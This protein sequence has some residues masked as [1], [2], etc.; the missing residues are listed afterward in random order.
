MQTGRYFCSEISSCTI[1]DLAQ[2]IKELFNADNEI[3]IIAPG[4]EKT[5]ETLLTREEMVRAEDLVGITG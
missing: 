5:Y 2:A 1:A 3:R 4:M